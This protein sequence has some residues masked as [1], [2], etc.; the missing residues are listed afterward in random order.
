MTPS[1]L[2]SEIIW[3][4]YLRGDIE[5]KV[6]ADLGCGTG[7]LCY[8]ISILGGYCLCIDIDIESLKI[9]K[10]FFEEKELNVDVINADINYLQIK[11]DTVIQNPP[12]GVVNKGADL[13]FLSKALDI[14]KTVYS[15]HKSNEKSREL[16][17]RLGNKKG[18]NVTI[19]TQKFKMNAYYPW[20]KK[21]IHEF[22][23]DIYLFSKSN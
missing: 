20:H 12:F 13:L 16:I 8:G 11:A 10:E 5:N 4:A 14:S 7:K 9:A 19:L 22:L 15:I 23:V 18:F 2:A 6:V 21:R 1:Y 3:A 17:Y